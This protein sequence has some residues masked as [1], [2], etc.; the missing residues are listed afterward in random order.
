LK[1]YAILCHLSDRD[2]FNEII[3]L[4]LEAIL[5]SN[6]INF[7]NIRYY[8]IAGIPYIV[9]ECDEE[10]EDKMLTS[11]SRLSLFFAIFEMV[12]ELLLPMNA[13]PDY[14][15][16]IN[17]PSML[18]YQGKTNERFTR[19]MINLALCA[20]NSAIGD[21]A[22]RLL[23][24]VAGKCTTLYD[25]MML[26]LD[27][28]GI[29]IRNKYFVESA[30]FITKF[31]QKAKYKHKVKKEKIT[32]KKAKKVAE[33]F[34]MEYA[35]D[36][37]DFYADNVNAIKIVNG[38]TAQVDNYIKKNS[39]DMIVGDLPYGVQHGSRNDKNKSMTRNAVA[40]LEDSIGSWLKVIKKGGSLVLSFNEFTTPKHDME[41]VLEVAG[42]TVLKE[43]IYY[44]YQHMV[45][46]SIKRDLIV[47]IKE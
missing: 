47:A 30:N 3:L 5:S 18:K 28:Y 6:N 27:V 16:D 7:E 25:G 38:D 44:N 9:F 21:R 39:I 22:P 35:K 11:I 12:G 40:I 1:K 45:D 20:Q 46:S 2:N 34:T 24:P 26:G 10:I 15:F 13:D 41:K 33:A 36:K 43:D 32:D 37:K 31:M 14:A 4:E 23:D 29:E 42:M 17:I 8:D 19:L